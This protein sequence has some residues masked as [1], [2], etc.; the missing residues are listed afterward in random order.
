MKRKCISLQT[1]VRF[2]SNASAFYFKHK[3]VLVETQVRF[4]GDDFYVYKM[5]IY[6]K[7]IPM[8]RPCTI[9]SWSSVTSFS[10]LATSLSGT[11]SMALPFSATIR[12][13]IP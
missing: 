2:T 4:W 12:P 8:R 3:D 9:R 11:D 5:Y 7:Q 10:L 13:N 1:Q 6:P